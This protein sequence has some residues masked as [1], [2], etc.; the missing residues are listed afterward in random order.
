M[1]ADSP[2]MITDPST[3]KTPIVKPSDANRK[4]GLH[5][6]IVNPSHQRRDLMR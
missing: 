5:M 2:H 3:P 6:A 1:I 4:P